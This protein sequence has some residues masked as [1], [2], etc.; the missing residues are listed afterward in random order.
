M[1]MVPTFSMSKSPERKP[2]SINWR[3]RVYKNF[4][5]RRCIGSSHGW[6]ILLDH[7]RSCCWF[8]ILVVFSAKTR[9]SARPTLPRPG[10]LL[11]RFLL[12]IVH[13][14]TKQVRVRRLFSRRKPSDAQVRYEGSG[15]VCHKS[16]SFSLI[17]V[18]RA[19]FFLVT[20]SKILTILP[21][22]AAFL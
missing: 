13:V 20:I 1:S 11:V 3:N 2:K 18:P 6:L 10:S 8:E 14:Y 9:T 5:K 16:Y 19:F 7:E 12:Q 4:G 15:N 17:S 21:S 22:L